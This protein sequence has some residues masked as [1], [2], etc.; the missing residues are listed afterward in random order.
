MTGLPDAVDVREVGPR[1]GLQPERP[2]APAD[3]ARLV[4]ALV[5]AGVRHVEV[6]AFV[7]P[8]AVPAMAGAGEVFAAVERRPGVTYAALVPNVRGAELAL[9]AGADELTVTISA[10]EAYNRRNV[11]MTVEESVAAIAAIGALAG[12]VPV[13]AVVSCAFGSP[14]EGD[15]APAAVARLG[16]R[17]LAG[18][19]TSLTWA[20]TTGMATPRR[21]GE[22]VALTGPDVGLHLHDTRGTAMVNAYAALGLGVRRFDTSVAGLGGSPFAAGATGNLATEELVAVLDDLGVATGID[23]DALVAV[24]RSVADLVGHPVPS[25]VAAAGPRSWLAPAATA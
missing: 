12:P 21:V 19:A 24:A 14:Y 15:L 4:D 23:V 1:D 8:K 9:E 2:V 5:A 25:R 3:R 7:S 11:R 10:S 17:L 13:D 18:G 20:D 16:E 22:L 6:A